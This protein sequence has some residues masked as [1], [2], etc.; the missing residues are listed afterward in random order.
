MRVGGT[1]GGENWRALRGATPRGIDNS[2]TF[3]AQRCVGISGSQGLRLA[4]IPEPD[5]FQPKLSAFEDLKR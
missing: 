3:R 1:S 2:S 4:G 5:L